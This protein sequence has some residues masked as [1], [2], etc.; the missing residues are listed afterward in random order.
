VLIRFK[1][2]DFTTS[3][4]PVPADA[5][6]RLDVAVAIP[7]G[8]P[9]PSP[10]LVEALGAGPSGVGHLL[11]ASIG[12]GNSFADDRDSDGVPDVCDNCPSTVGADQTDSDGDG[13]GDLCDPCPGD[14]EDDWDAD[15]LCVPE[16]PCPTD[17][18]N[19]VD[20]D[21]A[22]A[23]ADNCPSVSNP[24]Q[25]DRDEDGT[26][27]ACDN[28]PAT[29][30]GSLVLDD[31]GRGQSDANGDG[32]GDVCQCG[33]MNGDGFVNGADL[34]LY[35]RRFGGLL[36]PFSVERCGVSPTPDGGAC[37]GADFTVIKRHF[38]GFPPGI[39]NSCSAYVGP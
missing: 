17:P 3:L 39:T 22:C 25:D 15:G 28:C 4:D 35:K 12:V 32:I 26:G 9:A 1:T 16:D 34:T 10:V 29:S 5:A 14:P 8:V 36:S 37:D 30:N 7:D 38:G 20:G 31:A 6:G 19:D 21:G 11:I 23:A 24:D 27:N 33:D 2:P 13:L 18:Q